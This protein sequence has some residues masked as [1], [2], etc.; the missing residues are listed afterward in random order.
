M[1]RVQ[2]IL[3]QAVLPV[4]QTA[5]SSGMDLSSVE[6]FSLHSG[7]RRLIRTGLLLDIP[8]GMEVQIRPRSG[9][10]KTHGV[11]VLNSPSTIDSDYHGEL[12]VLLINHGNMEV[13]FKAGDR[14][15]QMVVAA[16]SISPCV[17]VDNLDQRQPTTRHGGFGSTGV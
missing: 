8:P 13:F 12:M 16:V 17:E 11:T 15:A 1:I 14:I 7:E 2:R 5:G 9:L 10:A 3:P 6:S 4:R